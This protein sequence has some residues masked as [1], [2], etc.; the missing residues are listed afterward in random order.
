MTIAL[1]VLMVGCSASRPVKSSD[2]ELAVVGTVLG[3]EVLYEEL[4]FVTLTYRAMLEQTYGEGIFDNAE[5]A[6]HYKSLL[7]EYVYGNIT[8]NY[9]VLLM[10]SRVGISPDEEVVVKA[11][12]DSV[13]KTVKSLGG[14]SKYKKYLA[15]SFMTD[16]FLRF[17]T[18]VDILQN[19]LMYVYIDDIGYITDDDSEIYDIIK[20]D[21][22][23]TRHIYISKSNGKSEAENISAIEQALSRLNE[24]EDFMTLVAEYGEDPGMTAEGYCFPKGYMSEKYEEAAFSLSAGEHSGIVEDAGGYYII[25]R[26]EPETLYIMTHF[27]ELKEIYQKYTFLA[28]VDAEQEKLVFEPNEY[29]KSI[30]LTKI[31]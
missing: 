15:E 20:K 3:Y 4:R 6:E 7:E 5:T 25:E 1:T 18:R 26:R 13:T 2:E 28:M 8:A 24:G 19:E 23:C 10:C 17:S 16:H 27:S 31:S 21:F 9:A 11:A 12:D 29:C 22:A 14:R 30:D